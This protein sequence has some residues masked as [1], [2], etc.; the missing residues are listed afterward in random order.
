MT[1]VDLN[2]LR[3]RL[4]EEYVLRALFS[5][6]KHLQKGEYYSLADI[7]ALFSPRQKRG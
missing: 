6:A 3:D 5:T 7:L 4:N 1:I 2:E